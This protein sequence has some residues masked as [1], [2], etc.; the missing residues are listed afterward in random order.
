VQIEMRYDTGNGQQTIAIQPKTFIEWEKTHKRTTASLAESL[1]LS[2]MA[3][4]VHKQLERN[5]DKPGT[6]DK[7]TDD[8]EDIGVAGGDPT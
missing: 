6:F 4:L 3:W 1:G 7:W 2:D 8:L 5:G